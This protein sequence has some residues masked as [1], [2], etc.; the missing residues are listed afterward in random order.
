MNAKITLFF[1]HFFMPKPNM[2]Y[3]N[4]RGK[5]FEKGIGIIVL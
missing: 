4:N 3:V 5:S 2:R 1:G